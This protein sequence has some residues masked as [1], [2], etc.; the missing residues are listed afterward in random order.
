MLKAPL[1][2]GLPS[3]ILPYKMFSLNLKN[4]WHLI[5]VELVSAYSLPNYISHRERIFE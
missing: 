4:A 1:T 2:A 5:F 3:S